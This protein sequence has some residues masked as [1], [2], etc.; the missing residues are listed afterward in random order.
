MDPLTFASVVIDALAWPIS[1]LLTAIL[2]RRPLS[3]LVASLTRLKHGEFELEFGQSI[4]SVALTASDRLPELQEHTH[5]TEVRDKVMKLIPVSPTAAI[6]EAWRHLETVAI[7][8]A[9]RADVELTDLALRKPIYIGGA[10]HA[11]DVISEDDMKL[12]R[13]LRRLRNEAVHYDK[14]EVTN[15]QAL[16]YL[17]TAMRLSVKMRHAVL[18]REAASS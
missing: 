12:F 8:T 17:D 15:E 16:S 13:E 9:K 5:D 14:M 3:E 7:E 2:F 11:H 18:T 10:L 4:K 6:A 1:I